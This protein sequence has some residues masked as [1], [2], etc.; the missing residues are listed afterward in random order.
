M[1]DIL[2]QRK[3]GNII[4]AVF[5]IAFIITFIVLIINGRLYERRLEIHGPSSG[6]EIYAYHADGGR[7]EVIKKLPNGTPCELYEEVGLT[8]KIG[9]T[10]QAKRYANVQC[11]G[12]R[13]YV[14]PDY[15]RGKYY[16]K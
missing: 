15:L 10:I 9:G 12:I 8:F 16:R 7:L 14:W 11:A 6:V 5:I 13:G 1:A 3:I 4:I 2:K